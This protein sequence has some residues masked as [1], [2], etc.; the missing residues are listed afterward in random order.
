MNL[1]ATMFGQAISFILFVLFCMKYIW[2]PL[3]SAID[4][5]QKEIADSIYSV[6]LSKK[7]LDIAQAQAVDH[8]HKA[9][10]DACGIIEQAHKCKAQI[11]NEAKAEAEV[12]R[13]KILSKTYSL[14]NDERKRLKQELR[15]QLALL[16]IAGAEKIIEHSVSESN[17][18]DIIDN[19]IAKL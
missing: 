13:N 9:K 12:E 3:I 17:N 8:L 11:I 16:A 10:L 5:R 14:I 18:I 4:K 15:N 19:I 7:H 2:P 6:E 1:N